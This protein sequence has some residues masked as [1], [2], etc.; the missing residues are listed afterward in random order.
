MIPQVKKILLE[1]R[2]R[3]MRNKELLKDAYISNDYVCIFDNGKEITPNYLTKKFH[4][5]IE[6]QNDIPQIRFHDLRHPYVKP[7]TKKY[8]FFLVLMIQ[9][10]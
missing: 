9:L 2:E 6:K 7:T 10:S 5:L 8:L 3:Q 4:M 1:Q